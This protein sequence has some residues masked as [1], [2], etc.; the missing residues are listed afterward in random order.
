MFWLLMGLSI[1]ARNQDSR[2][3]ESLNEG[4]FMVKAVYVDSEGVK[5]FGTN[6]GLCRYDD[7]TWRYYTDAD[8]LVGNQVNALTFEQ[9]DL[10][11]ALWVATTEGVSMV[12]FDGDGITESTGYTTGDGLLDNDVA[13]IAIDSR[14][15]KF[16]GSTRGITWFHD[17]SIDLIT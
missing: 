2:N 1:T 7:L 17:G 10:G 14:H 13:D 9:T 11:S 15:G 6:K 5:W 3:M 8:Y 16:F 12:T 4:V